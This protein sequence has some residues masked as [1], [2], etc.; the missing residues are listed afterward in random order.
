MIEGEWRPDSDYLRTQGKVSGG[1]SE[2]SHRY[3]SG[4]IRGVH[5]DSIGSWALCIAT[6]GAHRSVTLN[7][8]DIFKKNARRNSSIK[9]ISRNAR[10][11]FVT[12]NAHFPR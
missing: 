11:C 5:F 7:T 3:V 9:Y 12:I 6:V 10:L 2:R 4:R 8:S 1:K